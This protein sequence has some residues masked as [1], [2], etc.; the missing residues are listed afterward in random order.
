MFEQ[1]LTIDSGNRRRWTVIAGFSG[2]LLALG[3]AMLLPLVY[4]DR[5]PLFRLSDFH[6]LAP[7]GPPTPPPDRP[8]TVQQNTAAHTTFRDPRLLYAY[9]KIPERLAVIK[10]EPLAAAMDASGA[11]VPGAIPNSGTGAPG[12]PV[13]TVIPVPP[14]PEPA[15]AVRS[16]EPT[17]KTPIR[18]K[19]GGVVQSAKLVHRVIP[20]YPALAR[21]A[22]VSGVVQLVAIIGKDGTVQQLQVLSGHPLLVG[23]ALDAVRQW[24]YR[25]TLLNGQ[26]V[27][28]VAPIDVHFTL[29]Q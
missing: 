14:P 23:A 5:L 12:I 16:A 29:G 28:V 11:Y 7:S 20:S 2:Q 17:P 27:E 22:R 15:T 18:I 26:P 8:R 21:Q 25:P 10:D 24:I 6:I 1:V 13:A 9:T 19:V 3:A 4:T